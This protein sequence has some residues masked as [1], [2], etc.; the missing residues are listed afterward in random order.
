M[1]LVER[2]NYYAKGILTG[3]GA[4]VTFGIAVVAV[5]KDGTVDG[6]DISTLTAAAFALITTV[7]AVVKKRNI[8]PSVGVE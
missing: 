3:I 2:V 7:I 1:T 6:G 5:T 4:V 8:Y